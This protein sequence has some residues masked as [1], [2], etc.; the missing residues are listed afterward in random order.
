MTH[1]LPFLQIPRLHALPARVGAGGE[2]SEA[3]GD[4]EQ[5]RRED[6]LD[7]PGR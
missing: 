1:Y 6:L 4:A 7:R 5:R 3:H 2:G